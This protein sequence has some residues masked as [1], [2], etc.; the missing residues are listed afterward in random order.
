MKVRNLP[1][2]FLRGQPLNILVQT[3]MIVIPKYFTAILEKDSFLA[4]IKLSSFTACP[5][6]PSSFSPF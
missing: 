3:L 4:L 2:P 1:S 5:F 6:F